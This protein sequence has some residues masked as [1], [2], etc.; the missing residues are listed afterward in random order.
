[1]Q[2]FNIVAAT[3]TF[4]VVSAI[5]RVEHG[6][7]NNQGH[8]DHDNHGYGDHDNQGYG[9]RYGRRGGD[10]RGKYGYGRVGFPGYKNVPRYCIDF[11]ANNNGDFFAPPYGCPSPIYY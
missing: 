5:V 8:V 11:Y 6:D 9:G 7:H 2:F 10:R 3:I 1:M 4:G